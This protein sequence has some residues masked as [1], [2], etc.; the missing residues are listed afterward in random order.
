VWMVLV[1]TR[2]GSDSYLSYMEIPMGGANSVS[3]LIPSGVWHGWMGLAEESVV[4]NIPDNL[5]NHEEPDEQRM[6]PHSFY[7]WREIDG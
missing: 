2:K 5:Y 1:D 7:N 6:P 4:I 3:V